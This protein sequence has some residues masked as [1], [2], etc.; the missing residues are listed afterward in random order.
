MARLIGA[1][2]VLAF[3]ERV[4]LRIGAMRGVAVVALEVVAE[5]DLP[6]R[7]HRIGFAV[8][9]LRA[10]QSIRAQLR[11]D[12]LEARVEVVGFGIEVDEDHAEAHGHAR[13]LQAE[14]FLA[15]AFQRVHVPRRAQA[16]VGAV[17]PAVV[18]ADERLAVA[19]AFFAHARTAM[20][21]AV[22]QRTDFAVVAARDDHRL[23]GDLVQEEVAGR[24]DL[25]DVPPPTASS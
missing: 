19:L 1:T 20:P 10:V 9:D 22:D 24:R 2:D 17:D 8:R 15:E 13:L 12:L 23:L 11:I 5:R 4:D 25:A 18:R 14:V 16:A 6:V 7:V 21:A 3:L